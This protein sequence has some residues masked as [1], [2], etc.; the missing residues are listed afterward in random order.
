MLSGLS[1]KAAMSLAHRSR[2]NV[3]V[4]HV[5]LWLD[6]NTDLRPHAA[7]GPVNLQ[8]ERNPFVRF[9]RSHSTSMFLCHS[10]CQMTGRGFLLE[11]QE[12]Q[13]GPVVQFHL[14]LLHPKFTIYFFLGKCA[15]PF[16]GCAGADNYPLSFVT[17]VTLWS[18][19]N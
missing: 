6:G 11:G 17:S 1:V 16:Y 5:L 3:T 2:G 10:H 15:E 18:L 19:G 14:A 8:R 13:V 7:D 4:S 12:G 9:A